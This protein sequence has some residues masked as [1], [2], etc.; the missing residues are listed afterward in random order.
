MIARRARAQDAAAIQVQCR[1][2]GG[3]HSSLRVWRYAGVGLEPG[4]TLP[5]R[6]DDLQLQL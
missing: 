5:F 1:R 3:R 6:R 2:P 4:A